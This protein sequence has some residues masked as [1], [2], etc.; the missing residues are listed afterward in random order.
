MLFIL[1][2]KCSHTRHNWEIRGHKKIM[3]ASTTADDPMG[4]EGNEGKN[5]IQVT[6]NRKQKAENG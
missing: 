3:M 5:Y 1:T 6:G 2:S 4:L